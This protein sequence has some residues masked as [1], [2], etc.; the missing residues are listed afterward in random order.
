MGRAA[1]N[2]KRCGLPV[3]RRQLWVR[4]CATRQVEAGFRLLGLQGLR[5][6]MKLGFFFA[7][8]RLANPY[9]QTSSKNDVQ[10]TGSIT[11]PTAL[12]RRGVSD[13]DVC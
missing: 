7:P 3:T 2:L 8:A 6:S 5:G 12:R 1:S 9:F 11:L 13:A 10:I 4:S